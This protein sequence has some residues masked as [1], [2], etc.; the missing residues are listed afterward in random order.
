M[1]STSTTRG[2][3][4]GVLASMTF[5]TSGALM[6]PLL[7]SGWSPAA[8]VTVRAAIAG[9]VLLPIALVAVRGRWDAVWRARWRLLGMGLIGVAATQLLYFAAILRIPV[10]TA[11]LTEYLAPL[12]LV[13]FVWVTTRRA[14]K[15]VVLIGAAV[16]IGGLV[17]VV[18]PWSI[19]AVDG[20]GLAFAGLAA[21]GCAF[22][23]AL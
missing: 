4:I 16:A 9:L 23:S 18:S 6:K 10:S 17:L 12:L 13:A 19:A 21:V 14:P 1:S 2:L 7:E 20:L 15:L 8:A 11:L 22:Y 5:G 3:V